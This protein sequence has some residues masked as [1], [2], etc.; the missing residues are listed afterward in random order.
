MI[1]CVQLMVIMSLVLLISTAKRVIPYANLVLDL[2]L[3]NVFHVS[4]IIPL[5][6]TYFNL[7]AYMIALLKVILQ[8]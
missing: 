2:P 5:M 8:I 4:L 3:M 6:S 7:L 1:V